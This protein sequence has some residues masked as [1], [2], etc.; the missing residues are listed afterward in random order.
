[1]N[2]HIQKNIYIFALKILDD[3]VVQV[4]E[5]ETVDVTV[6]GRSSEKLIIRHMSTKRCL[7]CSSEDLLNKLLSTQFPCKRRLIL[8]NDIITGY[9][10]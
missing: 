9:E 8:Q 10:K 7:T 2:I 3:K 6:T 1:M 5:P 4:N